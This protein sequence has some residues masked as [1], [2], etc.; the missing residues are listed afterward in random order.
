MGWWQRLHTWT[1]LIMVVGLIGTWQFL[2]R[3]GRITVWMTTVPRQCRLRTSGN[4]GGSRMNTVASHTVS[5]NF[6]L[7]YK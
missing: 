1:L 4:E 2:Y 6:Q 7:K 3:E 5:Y